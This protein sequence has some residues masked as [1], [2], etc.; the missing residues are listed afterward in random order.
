MAPY[1]TSWGWW[2]QVNTPITEFRI[3]VFPEAF[4]PSKSVMAC[5]GSKTKFL[6]APALDLRE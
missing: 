2:R 3:E 1:T 5:V 4:Q 6:E